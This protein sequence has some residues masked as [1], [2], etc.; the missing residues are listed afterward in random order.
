LQVAIFGVLAMPR[1]LPVKPRTDTRTKAIKQRERL[2]HFDLWALSIGFAAVLWAVIPYLTVG[3]NA[4]AAF[5][6][7]A[8]AA[9]IALM[10]YANG[11]V[12]RS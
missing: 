9:I 1:P 12:L 2:D 4:G 11:H 5:V 6:I 3:D 8:A 7:A 10:L